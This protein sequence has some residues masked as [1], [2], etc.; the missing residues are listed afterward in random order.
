VPLDY[1][2]IIEFDG[3]DFAEDD[4]YETGIGFDVA[5]DDPS[6]YEGTYSEE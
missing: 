6:P 4:S 3:D 2:D 1:E 5:D